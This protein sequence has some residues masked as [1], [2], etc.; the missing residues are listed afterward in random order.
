M[1]RNYILLLLSYLL[2]LPATAAPLRVISLDLCTD[3]M[4]LNYASRSQVLAYSPLLYSYNNRR[5]ERGL[6]Q[7]N[8]S[9]EQIVSLQPDLVISGEYNAP[10]L[11]ERLKQ[12]GFKVVVLSLPIHLDE[13]RTYTQQFLSILH[14]QNNTDNP[15]ADYTASQKHKSLLLL[16]ANGIGTGKNTLEDD[17]LTA[18]GWDNYLSQSG[19]ISLNLEQ[20]VSDPPDA[21]YYS[22]PLNNS[23]ANLFAQHPVI[24]QP[25][26]ARSVKVE[27]NWRWQCPGPWT[28]ELIREL[29][30]W[31]G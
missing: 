17:V 9:L 2:S 26:Q 24:H 19:Y 13:V 25:G 11:R 18:A 3:Y 4:L 15:L 29:A 6:R 12:L 23:L 5:I 20:L 21:I 30:R 16:G 10:L 14:D 22:A 7:H 1:M 28:Y 31:T 27:D 8:G